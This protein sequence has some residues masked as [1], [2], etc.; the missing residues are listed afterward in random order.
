MK[1]TQRGSSQL[2][3]SRKREA[4]PSSAKQYANEQRE[5]RDGLRCMPPNIWSLFQHP[6]GYVR[7][8]CFAFDCAFHEGRFGVFFPPYPLSKVRVLATHVWI[9]NPSLTHPRL[10]KN[11]GEWDHHFRGNSQN[12]IWLDDSIH[13]YYSITKCMVGPRKMTSGLPFPPWWL[14]LSTFKLMIC[15]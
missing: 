13:H 11:L 2:S 15:P 9:C 5:E 14:M 3:D 1:G 10:S 8:M 12:T 7:A 6:N 4:D